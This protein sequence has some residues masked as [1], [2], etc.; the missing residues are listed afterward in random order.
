MT[1]FPPVRE[2]HLHDDPAAVGDWCRARVTPGA[3]YV[4]PSAAARRHAVR[5]AL[6]GRAAAVGVQA[7]A[8]GRLLPLL[9]ARAGLS[10]PAM[11][12]PA[13]ERLLV[14]RAAREAG[15]PLFDVEGAPRGAVEAVARLVRSL[16]LN[17]V[18][19]DAYRDAGGDAHAADAYARFEIARARL[20][21][22]DEPDQIERLLDAGVPGVALVL[23]DPA[24]PHRAALRLLEAA[25]AASPACAVGV[26]RLG[27]GGELPDVARRLEAMGFTA[28]VGAGGARSCDVR[29]IGGAGAQDEVELVAR[30]V[31]ALLRRGA[32]ADDVLL[33]A[34]S[35][36]YLSSLH[37][38]LHGVGV[39]VASPRRV[40]ALDVPV[41][42]ALLRAMRLL[43]SA[44]DDT[45]EAGLALLASPYVGLSLARHDRL[46][47]E[48]VRRG[49]GAMR[50][51]RTFAESET[52]RTFRELARLVPELTASLSGDRAPRELAHTLSRLALDVGFLSAGRRYHLA[53]GR[54]ESVRLDQQGWN[55]LAE[56]V[57]EVNEALRLAGVTRLSATRWIAMVG[58]A[59]GDASVRADARPL[60]GV[61]LSV[62]GAGLPPAEHV[63]AVGWRDGLVPRRLREEPFLSEKVKNE[64]N[65]RCGALFPL[66]ADRAALDIERRERVVRAARAT[67]TISWPALGPDGDPVLPSRYLDELGVERRETRAV[68][69]A[70]W[71]APLAATRLERL[72]RATVAAR[73]RPAASLGQELQVVRSTLAAL[74]REEGRRWTGA[75]HAPRSVA[76]PPE[77]RAEAAAMAAVSSASQAR[78]LAHCLYAHFGKR[79]LALEPVA[80]PQLDMRGLGKVAHTVL[81]E[82][83]R[84]GFV[85][86]AVG[87]LFDEAWRREVPRTLR[88][89][90][91]AEFQAEMLRAQLE[92]LVDAERA[93]M[94]A[95]GGAHHYELAFGLDDDGR[96]P[97]S[98]AEGIVVDLPA[99]APVATVTLRGSIDR[100]DIIERD[101]KR[102]AIAV[103]YK[104]GKGESYAKEMEDSADFQL[105]IYCEMLRAFGAEPVGAFYAGIASAERHGVVRSDFAHLA[106]KASRT[107]RVLEPEAF[108]A[109]VHERMDAL[110]THL[111]KAANAE[112]EIA[113]RQDDCKYC[114][115]RPVCR[116]GTFRV[117][118]AGRADD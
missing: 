59:L 60:D 100:V 68:G 113:P 5:D 27:E 85:R 54:D 64:L 11:M 31:L 107:M 81:M 98:L 50:E 112:L 30:H 6:A 74:T 106:P 34:P 57:D 44:E 51:W 83:G 23:E 94:D 4:A 77:V 78:M 73:H 28:T 42:S 26:P 15:V 67:L 14:E 117:A 79:R 110:R 61:R 109:Y 2:L 108:D 89:T 95:A 71:P 37:D 102:Y 48:L 91:E 70:T 84:R 19:P 86:E 87:P 88:E 33:V 80:P 96:D 47:R 93:W 58:E 101:G 92:A 35:S 43:A 62:A 111:V 39:P 105:P 90:P 13:L 10:A 7:A 63:F 17:G 29:A 25:I 41:V 36:T 114:D 75:L 76:L 53:A 40:A 72:T 52:S 99:G 1:P 12:S 9:E 45:P 69:D 32:R 116:V 3:L 24:V 65:E 97:A 16:R 20:G 38:A 46:T 56:S 22:F 103:D 115:L 104:L 66:A 55:C 118:T 18:S 49:Q 8:R 82:L 21:L